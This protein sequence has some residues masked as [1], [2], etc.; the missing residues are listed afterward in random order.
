MQTMTA[1]SFWIY[2]DGGATEG[3]MTRDE[4]LTKIRAGHLRPTNQVMEQ[5]KDWEPISSRY[6]LL[7]AMPPEPGSVRTPTPAPAA[8][9]TSQ[10]Q[11]NVSAQ[12]VPAL[13]ICGGL[14]MAA[15]FF[16]WYDT[17]TRGG[18]HNVGLM[19]DRSIGT[20]VGIGLSI[21]GAVLHRRS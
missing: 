6:D 9:G 17:T 19:Q 5:G 1:P 10:A 13:L 21:L 15:Y 12:L 11:G 16:F 8:I 14:I 7:V 18:V 3:P 2:L 20:M 4:L